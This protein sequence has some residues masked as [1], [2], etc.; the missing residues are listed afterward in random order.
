LAALKGVH[1]E[2]FSNSS[3][4]TSQTPDKFTKEFQPGGTL[5]LLCENW[6]SRV[7][8][9]GTDPYGLGRWSHVTLG[10]RRSKRILIVTAYRVSCELAGPMT[11]TMQQFCNI[12]RAQKNQP[13]TDRPRP[14]HQMIMD[15]QAWL[16]AEVNTGYKIILSID[17]NEEYKPGKG[18]IIPLS[19]KEGNH[20]INSNHDG[21]ISTLCHSCGLVDPHTTLQTDLPPPPTYIRGNSRLDYIFISQT[22]LHSVERAGI[23]P[24]NS[25]FEGDHRPCYL[26]FS[27]IS[28]FQEN[29]YPLAPL[30]H[31]GL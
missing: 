17:A 15:L 7:I 11:A 31:R 25:V 28:L 26:D 3:F 30:A 4:Q 5:T 1:S 13:T 16:E 24:Y 19:Y 10:G 20:I 2:V 14:Q 21:T 29:D 12:S 23:L 6:S 9:K 8:E 18:N 22:L 27:A